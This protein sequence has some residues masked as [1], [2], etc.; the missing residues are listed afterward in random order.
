MIARLKQGLK[1][2]EWPRAVGPTSANHFGTHVGGPPLVLDGLKNAHVATAIQDKTKPTLLM[3]PT[4]ILSNPRQ[5][6]TKWM[7]VKQRALR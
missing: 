1:S 5:A 2:V 6:H 3:E 4:R 7:R